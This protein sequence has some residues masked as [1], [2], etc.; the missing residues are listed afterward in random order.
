MEHFNVIKKAYTEAREIERIKIINYLKKQTDENG[1]PIF[2]ISAQG[3]KGV[4]KYGKNKFNKSFD[5]S[6]W[7]WI[8]A[9][10][11]NITVL[12]SLQSFDLDENSHNIHI[13]YDRIGLYFYD[14]SGKESVLEIEKDFK[15]I[16]VNDPFVKMLTTD[17]ELP[18]SEKALADLSKLI[19]SKT[20]NK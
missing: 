15:T 10:I 18:L 4:S 14:E 1:N 9:T 13:L 8:T 19:I 2:K 20:L 12:I 3:G 11:N 16:K 7:K 5:L 6:N 17:F